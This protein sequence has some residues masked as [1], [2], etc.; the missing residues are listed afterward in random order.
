MKKPRVLKPSNII[1][2][3]SRKDQ[4]NRMLRRQYM[5]PEERI[6]ELEQDIVRLVDFSLMVMERVDN[7]AKFSRRLIRLVRQMVQVPEASSGEDS[8][9]D[10]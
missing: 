5:T 6:H 7:Q 9:V 2:L 3:G 8:E 4:K 10:F 1:S